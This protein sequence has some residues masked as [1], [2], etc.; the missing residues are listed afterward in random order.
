MKYDGRGEYLPPD[1]GRAGGE[2]GTQGRVH[3]TAQGAHT[4]GTRHGE[5]TVC[6]VSLWDNKYN[7]IRILIPQ[8]T[9]EKKKLPVCI[10]RTNQPQTDH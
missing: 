1:E 5:P 10:T 6:R 4:G 7:S 3:V 2:A 8:Y 9:G